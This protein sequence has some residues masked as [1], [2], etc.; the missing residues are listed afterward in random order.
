MFVLVKHLKLHYDFS[1]LQSTF[2]LLLIILIKRLRCP[3]VAY[4]WPIPLARVDCETR[5]NDE[6]L[7]GSARSPG[8]CEEDVCQSARHARNP[9]PLEQDGTRM[10]MHAYACLCIV[11]YT[12]MIRDAQPSIVQLTEQL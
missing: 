6:R 1:H 12:E 11:A 2:H 5:F 8:A 10:P 9:S 7:R 4:F 3:F